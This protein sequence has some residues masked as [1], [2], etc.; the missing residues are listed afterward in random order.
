MNNE[1]RPCDLQLRK[2]SQIR[3]QPHSEKRE[4]TFSIFTVLSR[5]LLKKSRKEVDERVT[6][7]YSSYF[8][9]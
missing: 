4:K 6:L 2:T 9:P 3:Q 7:Y 5:S 1:Q 8:L